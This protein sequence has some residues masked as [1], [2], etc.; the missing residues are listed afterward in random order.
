MIGLPTSSVPEF[1]TDLTA[2]NSTAL[3]SVPGVSPEII[4]AGAR[5]LLDTYAAS[6]HNVW[7]TAVGFVALAA[8]G[9]SP[10]SLGLSGDNPN[11]HEKSAVSLLMFDPSK[12]FNN[13][14]DAPVEKEEE[15]YSHRH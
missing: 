9:K 4:G 6:F 13:H 10:P 2:Q 8:I 1:I 7:V 12:E 11:V 15:L 14:I 5:A 3:L